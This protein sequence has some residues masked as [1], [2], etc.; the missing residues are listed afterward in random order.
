R[1]Y[2]VVYT[3]SEDDLL[4]F[5]LTHAPG[6][7]VERLV[8]DPAED[9]EKCRQDEADFLAARIKALLAPPVHV[10]GSPVH[11]ERSRDSEPKTGLSA[12]LVVNRDGTLRPPR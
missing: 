12:T 2:E 5:R 6:P 3:P 4:A 11:V 8:Q 10:D 7:C 1:D 9:S